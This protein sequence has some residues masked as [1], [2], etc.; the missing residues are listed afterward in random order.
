MSI[1]SEYTH[2]LRISSSTPKYPSNETANRTSPKDI[3]RNVYSS[4]L[5]N[6][7]KLGPIQTATDGRMFKLTVV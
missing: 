7:P 4:I 3:Y 1:H 6:K 2:A 5:C